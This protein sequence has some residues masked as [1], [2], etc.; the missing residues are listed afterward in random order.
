M[1]KNDK[2]SSP[3]GTNDELGNPFAGE[4]PELEIGEIEAYANVALEQ[5][6]VI[7]H[8]QYDEPHGIIPDGSKKCVKLGSKQFKNWLSHTILKCEGRALGK[9]ARESVIQVLEGW[10][11]YQNE[12]RELD[13]RI[14]SYGSDVWYDLGDCRA[15]RIGRDGWKVTEEV[16]ILFRRMSHQN[17][18]VI[19]ETGGDV[20]TLFDFANI[21]GSSIG[22]STE[23]L[24]LLTWIVASFFPSIPHPI[25]VLHGPQGSAKTTLFRV[26]RMLID[27]SKTETLSFP[28]GMRELVQQAA[29]HYFL[30]FDNLSNMSELF[31]DALCRMCTGQGY[32]KRQL[33]TDDDDV[34]YSFK[35]TIGLNGI[36]IAPDKAD[37]LDRSLLIG[38]ERVDKFESEQK[39]W[40][41]FQIERPRIFGA[42]LDLTVKSLRLLDDI[43]EVPGLRM[44]D[45]VR[46]GCAVAESLELT[47]ERFLIAYRA[48]LN[49]QN[50]E[51][52][53]ASLVGAA[54]VWFMEDRDSWDGTATDLL[55]GLKEEAEKRGVDTNVR[56]W[57][58]APN[59]LWRRVKE[60]RTNLEH[61]GIVFG[62]HEVSAETIT[63]QKT[64]SGNAP[65]AG[66]AQ[67]EENARG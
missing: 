20:N 42:I 11:V 36:N 66:N 54:V 10:A 53:S 15:V 16:P 22:D 24:L 25:L 18:Q 47:R 12:K 50:N 37:L 64:G 4:F 39:F 3:G 48:N 55:R 65:N 49:R 31:S 29:H 19:P 14:V 26:L 58:K 35:R 38:L 7:F 30:P 46:V 8:D 9:S 17:I 59:W 34:I 40:Q 33:Y 61:A 13:V 63:I 43:Q 5:G 51:A 60:I 23:R 41:R 45:F 28:D 57:P 67:G 32:S 56:A 2:K 27:P 21:P 44:A 1:D 62:W 6:L 52:L